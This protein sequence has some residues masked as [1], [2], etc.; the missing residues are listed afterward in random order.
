MAET[1]VVQR[2]NIG[3]T[4][5]HI[6][7]GETPTGL[8]A[9]I[10]A[11]NAGIVAG[12]WQNH[13][14]CA[15]SSET[16]SVTC[17]NSWLVR[18]AN[19]WRMRWPVLGSYSRLSFWAYAQDFRV[20]VFNQMDFYV[21]LW[22]AGHSEIFYA[23]TVTESCVEGQ[24]RRITLEWDMEST[25]LSG[26]INTNIFVELKA[27]RTINNFPASNIWTFRMNEFTLVTANCPL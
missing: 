1:L 17:I 19:A 21:N 10:E 12:N 5:M 8:W 7:P 23:G 15:P 9:S 26:H 25:G 22:N 18:E 6:E 13:L 27:R 11:Q 20:G 16:M 2:G 3:T 14:V 24:T 4:K